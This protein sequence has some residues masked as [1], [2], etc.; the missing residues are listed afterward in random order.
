MRS[1]KTE[2]VQ[3]KIIQTRNDKNDLNNNFRLEAEGQMVV[4]TLLAVRLL[5]KC[6]NTLLLCREIGLFIVLWLL[7][8]QLSRTMMMKDMTLRG[9]ITHMHNGQK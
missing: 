5:L 7:L 6:C 8:A 1:C 2:H 4:L 9:T 3:V